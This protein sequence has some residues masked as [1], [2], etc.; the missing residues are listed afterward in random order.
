M[1]LNLGCGNNKLDGYVNI[2]LHDKEADI[3]ADITDLPIKS[4][5]VEGIVAYQVIEHVPYWRAIEVFE[6]MYRVMKPGATAVIECPDMLYIAQQ[7][8][9]REDVAD[10]WVYNIWGEYYRPWDKN[11]HRDWEH[12]AA[13][14]HI[15]GFTEKKIRR[16]AE[17]AGFTQIRR[18][19]MHEVHP[20]YR[21]PETLS[22]ELTK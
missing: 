3:Q 12:N 13:S 22:M 11:R 20:D 4:N 18:R 5:S 7:I 16:L 17:Q 1:L 10:K 8:V 19:E 21:Y 9:D 15:N 2:D 14:L 6:E